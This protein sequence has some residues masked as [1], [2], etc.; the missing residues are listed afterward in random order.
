MHGFQTNMVILEWFS[1]VNHLIMS[2]QLFKCTN[3]LIDFTV[4]FDPVPVD[5]FVVVAGARGTRG[6]AQSVTLR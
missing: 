2:R 3:Q 4:S 5:R 6:R 1:V